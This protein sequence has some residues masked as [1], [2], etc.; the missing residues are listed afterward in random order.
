MR[1][2]AFLLLLPGSAFG[3]EL[4]TFENGQ[5]ADA[6]KIN[7]NFNYV[8]ENASGGC[9]VQQVDN[10]AEITCADGTSAVVPGYGTVVIV[11]EG[12][13]SGE[14]PPEVISGGTITLVDGNGDYLAPFRII[15]DSGPDMIIM[16]ESE[17][18]IPSDDYNPENPIYQPEFRQLRVV[19]RNREDTQQS[20]LQPE[21]EINLSNRRRPRFS[22]LEPDCAGEAYFDDNPP[23]N[24][25]DFFHWQGGYFTETDNDSDPN[26]TISGI[27]TK[28]YR[29]ADW[30]DH[31]T[32]EWRQSDCVNELD[33]RD[34]WT[35]WVNVTL[36]P[37]WDNIV[38]PV[39]LKQ[40][41]N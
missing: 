9:T 37:E 33:V 5:V 18:L 10:S 32:L 40:E 21:S 38:Y 4:H 3:Q 6:Q 17:F 19:F 15:R 1:L 20:Y 26:L 24:P 41:P 34:L 16:V 35:L 7:D 31:T 39:T 28:S 36:P 27:V 12:S 14:V 2:L 8:L 30:L 11:P 29:K 13:A 25:W 22:Y 23:I